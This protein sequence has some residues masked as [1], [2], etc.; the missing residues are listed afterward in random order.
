MEETE[1]H[2][3]YGYNLLQLHLA[4]LLSCQYNFAKVNTVL[5]LLGPVIKI[6]KAILL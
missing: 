2:N 4:P 5:E 6:Y 1:I 3:H